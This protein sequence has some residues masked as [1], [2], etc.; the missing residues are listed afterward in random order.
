M[1]TSI[2]SGV[3][4]GL[5][6]VLPASLKLCIRRINCNS[7]SITRPHRLIY[8]RMYP[9]VLVLPDGSS[10]NIRYHEPRKIITLPIDLS[11]LSEE[12]MK[13]RLEKRKPKKKIK[14]EEDI[15]D[16]FDVNKYAKYIKK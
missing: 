11:S 9:T 16:D 4:L 15:T 10:V 1:A 3:H 13:Q 8:A 7:A 2:C 12:E 6:N 5:K 14:I